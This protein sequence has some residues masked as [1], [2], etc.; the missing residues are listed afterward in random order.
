MQEAYRNGPDLGVGEQ[1]PDGGDHGRRDKGK[2][3]KRDDPEQ[4]I[5]D[6][7]DAGVEQEFGDQEADSGDVEQELEISIEGDNNNQCVAVLQI[8]DTG[9]VQNQQGVLQDGSEA[10]DIE[11]DG[12][13][14]TETP[15][16]VQD[17]RQEIQQAAAAEQQPNQRPRIKTKV[18]KTVH[19]G[20]EPAAKAA[21]VPTLAANA[22]ALAANA[23]AISRPVVGSQP[24]VGRQPMAG[25]PAAVPMGQLPRTGGVSIS[26]AALLGLGAG[27]LL[28]AGGLLARRILR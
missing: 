17:C 19:K 2:K 21:G 23:P 8:S 15:Q 9:N 10:D 4:V 13:E 7:E 22:P 20:V 5:D 18:V 6:E 3:A 11:A 27:P 14:I 24:V 16:M 12:G 28:I 1:E 25:R 26:G